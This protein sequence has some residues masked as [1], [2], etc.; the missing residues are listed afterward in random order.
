MAKLDTIQK[1]IK[2]RK[3]RWQHWQVIALYLVIYD[4]LAVNLAYLAEIGR[5]SCRERV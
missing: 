2:E 1:S 4:I 5:A 3:V